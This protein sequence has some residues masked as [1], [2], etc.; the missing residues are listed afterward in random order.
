MKILSLD[1]PDIAHAF[2][3]INIKLM[4]CESVEAKKMMISINRYES[5]VSALEFIIVTAISVLSPQ[6]D[7]QI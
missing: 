7:L 5:N 6:V 1:I 3:G 4:K 2:D